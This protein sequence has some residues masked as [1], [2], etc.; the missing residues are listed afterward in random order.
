M[1]VSLRLWRDVV[2]TKAWHRLQDPVGGQSNG[3]AAAA[4]HAA[5]GDQRQG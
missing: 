1:V 4:R 3:G 2:A 5:A